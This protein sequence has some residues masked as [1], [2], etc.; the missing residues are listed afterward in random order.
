VFLA[1]TRGQRQN[2]PQ[3][4]ESAATASKSSG[5]RSEMG[6][7]GSYESKASA[8]NGIESVQKN[9]PNATVVD[10]SEETAS[11]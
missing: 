2:R 4:V 3:I 7:Y 6:L 1:L 8:K 10:L 11:K 9:A 5:K